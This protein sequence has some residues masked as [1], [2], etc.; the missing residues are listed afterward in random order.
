MHNVLFLPLLF[1]AATAT[2]QAPCALPTLKLFQ[3]GVEMPADARAL[4]RPVTLRVLPAPGCPA[5]VY[6]FRHAEVTLVRRGRPVLPTLRVE[7]PQ[8]D[9]QSFLRYYQTGDQVV[10]FIAYQNLA[11]VAADGS[12]QPLA[13]APPR[14]SK[15]RQLD[16]QTEDSR[17][18]FLRWPRLQP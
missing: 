5:A 11:L 8:A 13:A 4:A 15:P 12:L 10:I 6:R 3:D 1:G 9:L 7:K 2:A 16:L 14:L 18:L 17:G